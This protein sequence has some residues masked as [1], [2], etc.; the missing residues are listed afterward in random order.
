MEYPG[1]AKVQVITGE[2]SVGAANWTA[3]AIVGA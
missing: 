1:R 2:A 3:I